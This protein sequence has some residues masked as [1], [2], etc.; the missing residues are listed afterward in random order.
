M[1]NDKAYRVREAADILAVHYQTVWTL[2]REGKL[3]ALKVSTRRTIVLESEINRYL[4]SL[5]D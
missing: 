5:H 4:E 2:I 1:V 3:K